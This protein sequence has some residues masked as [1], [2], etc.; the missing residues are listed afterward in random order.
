VTE[1]RAGTYFWR[2][3][4]VFKD[5]SQSRFSAAR[6]FHLE[7]IPTPPEPP[8]IDGGVLR[9]TW[10][11]RPGQ[12]F[13]LQLAADPR[14]E[15]LVEVRNTDRPAVDVPHPLPGTYFARVRTS[16]P[17]GSAGPFSSAIRFAVP[18]SSIATD[19]LVPDERGICAVYAPAPSRPPR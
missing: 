19:C 3:A 17:D 12:K 7:P 14:F 18:G 15:Y 6:L 2:V 13:T 16:S 5:G 11:G 4:S 9:F 10:A 8:T 1:L